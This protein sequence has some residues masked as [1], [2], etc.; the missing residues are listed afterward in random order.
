MAGPFLLSSLFPIA[1]DA[2]RTSG[3]GDPM[4]VFDYQASR[5]L[6][7][8]FTTPASGGALCLYVS[9]NSNPVTGGFVAY[10]ISPPEFPDYPK[11]GVAPTANAYVITVNDSQRRVYAFSRSAILAGAAAPGV[12]FTFPK[13]SGFGFQALTPA[14][15]SSTTAPPAGTPAYVARHRDTEVHG[16]TAPAGKDLIEVFELK[17]NYANPSASTVVLRSVQVPDFDSTLCGLST[18]DCVPQP[19]T[20]RKLDGIREVIM[21]PLQ[22]RK[23]GTAELLVGGFSVDGNGANLATPYWFELRRS[24]STVTFRQGGRFLPSTT[25]HRWLPSLGIDKQGNI[26][27]GFNSSAGTSGSF[28]SARITGRLAGD[29]LN[30]LRDTTTVKA[31]TGSQTISNRWGDYAATTVD[32][33]DNCTFWFTTEYI[34]TNGQWRTTI[35]AFKFPGC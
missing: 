23:N 14:T 27:M 6:L 1:S 25:L 3:L 18:L 8:E 11:L 7:M 32:P 5:F 31:G 9:N 10:K 21:Q 34:P 13:L 26:A 17:P 15:V 2:C 20:T 30:T 33:A 16:G 35:G 29:P 22:Y 19:G 12:V 24:T 28:P 4:V